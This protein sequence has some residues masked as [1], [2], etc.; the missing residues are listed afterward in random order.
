VA[1]AAVLVAAC[2][3]AV[4]PTPLTSSAPDTGA[5]A[6]PDRFPPI[7]AEVPGSSPPPAAP[8]WPPTTEWRTYTSGLFQY[9][10]SYPPTWTV[11]QGTPQFADE[12]DARDLPWLFVRRGVAES[13]SRT[14]AAAVGDDIVIERRDDRAALVAA[15]P[16]A[17]PGG[18]EGMYLLYH[19]RIRVGPVTVQRII[20]ANGPVFYYFSFYGPPHTEAADVALFQQIYGSWKPT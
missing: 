1:I 6:A 7:R 11:D 15:H 2:G 12:I 13:T 14:I 4:S 17:L 16:I 5:V 19:G 8:A 18:Y 3:S 20:V 9:E 10:I